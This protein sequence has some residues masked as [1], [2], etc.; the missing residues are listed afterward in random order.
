VLWSY[1]PYHCIVRNKQYPAVMMVSGDSDQTCN[2]FHA[3][4]M[5]AR[6]QATN[7]SPH[8]IILDYNQ[9]RGHAPVLPLSTRV[10]ALSDRVAFLC[11]QL[12]LT[13]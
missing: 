9:Y 11:D 8:P 5:V 2:P 4:K 12:T 6:L 13:V 1:S 10:E 7:T 3:R